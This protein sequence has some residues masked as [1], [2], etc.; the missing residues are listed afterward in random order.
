MAN[1]E[2]YLFLDFDGVLNTSRYAKQLRKEGIDPFDEFG[3]MF[4]PDAISNLRNIVEQTGCKIRGG[5]SWRL[6]SAWRRWGRL[7]SWLRGRTK[8]RAAGRRR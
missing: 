1:I 5:R 2:K 3:A 8:A 7:A 6:L 4:D